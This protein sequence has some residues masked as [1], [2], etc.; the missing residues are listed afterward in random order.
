V[1]CSSTECPICTPGPDCQKLGECAYYGL[2]DAS[3]EWLLRLVARG[4][5]LELDP[6][7]CEKQRQEIGKQV[8]AEACR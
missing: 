2:S 1:T 6:T 5:I 3:D 4:K 7:E 8:D